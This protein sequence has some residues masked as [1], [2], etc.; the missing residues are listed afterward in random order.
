MN[1]IR[2]LILIVALTGCASQGAIDKSTYNKNLVSMKLGADKQEFI[3]LFPDAEPRGA[4]MYPKGQVE[5]YEQKVSRYTPFAT[6][7]AGYQ[8]N[9]I[10]GVETKITWFYFF[11]DKLVQYGA[12][13]DWPREPDQILEIRNR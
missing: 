9:T 11:N 2:A 3:K 7:D 4:R 1:K 6:N 13:H 10:T 12:P 5:V 8:R